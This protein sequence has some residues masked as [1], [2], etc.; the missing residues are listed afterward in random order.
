MNVLK[1][2]SFVRPRNFCNADTQ[3]RLQLEKLLMLLAEMSPEKL[4]LI[5]V[6]VTATRLNY[7]NQGIDLLAPA[8]ERRFDARVLRE[9]D[10]DTRKQRKEKNDLQE[11]AGMV[12]LA[13][14]PSMASEELRP[15]RVS[16]WTALRIGL[17]HINDSIKKLKLLG[18]RH[19]EFDEVLRH[20]GF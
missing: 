8:T 14:V 2:M 12:W 18:M 15:L 1:T 10:R 13:T 17:P 3:T 5:L 4:A 11:I 6:L 20:P 19:F 16:L 7:F 9:I